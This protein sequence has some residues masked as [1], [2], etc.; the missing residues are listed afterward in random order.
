MATSTAV[1]RRFDIVDAFGGSGSFMATPVATTKAD[2]TV[3]GNDDQVTHQ[4]DAHCTSTNLVL[5]LDIGFI[6]MEL[7]NRTCLLRLME[8]CREFYTAGAILLLRQRIR[9]RDEAAFKSFRSF[10]FATSPEPS[11]RLTLLRDLRIL[12][13]MVEHDKST[14]L[15]IISGATHLRSLH[16]HLPKSAPEF[17]NVIAGYTDLR[18][19]RI[20][21]EPGQPATE[22][23]RWL[24]QI[25]SPIDTLWIKWYTYSPQRDVI[26]YLAPLAG[27]LKSL[28][29]DRAT[30]D[31]TDAN[32]ELPHVR[33]LHLVD[34]D[35]AS[36]EHIPPSTS[37]VFEIFPN[38]EFLEVPPSD[39]ISRHLL[40]R[41]DD[42]VQE[43][44][45]LRVG[46]H[47]RRLK[48]LEGCLTELTYGGYMCPVDE[49]CLW[50]E[51]CWEW[52]RDQVSFLLSQ[53]RP[54]RFHIKFYDES[55]TMDVI[56]IVEVV[57]SLG[58]FKEL[59]ILF[60]VADSDDPVTLEIT[61]ALPEALRGVDTESLTLQF[62]VSPR[63]TD[64]SFLMHEFD[65]EEFFLHVH[66]VARKP[67]TITIEPHHTRKAIFDVPADL[68]ESLRRK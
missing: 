40:S 48:R 63:H 60:Y 34:T 52:E 47:Q 62:G 65:V 3:C 11:D 39:R 51:P 42:R 30:F 29:L 67:R 5:P 26:P 33:H 35:S 50:L 41:H 45:N 61:R 20:D 1:I 66:A 25:R 14:V 37:I 55:P 27:T 10:V 16:I 54:S 64:S 18:E 12:P 2:A 68:V 17:R 49:L 9:I 15:R 4:A 56:R 13:P 53:T 21:L 46:V 7:V 43:A 32:F 19:L 57:P 22:T 24:E 6:I 44:T 58:Y 59:L 31:L 28:T 23:L 8:T 38:L 36:G